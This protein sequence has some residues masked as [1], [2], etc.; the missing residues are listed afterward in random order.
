MAVREDGG[1]GLSLSARLLPTGAA[2]TD[3]RQ[4]DPCP[5]GQIVPV[6]SRRANISSLWGCRPAS[7]VFVPGATHHLSGTA[8]QTG[9]STTPTDPNTPKDQLLGDTQD[10]R[11]FED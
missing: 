7:T 11:W 2:L 3:S 8:G 5:A 4:G 1:L 9:R 10:R 6:S